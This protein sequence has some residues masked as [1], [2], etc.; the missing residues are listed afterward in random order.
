[1]LL[2]SADTITWEQECGPA[3]KAGQPFQLVN[4]KAG[5]LQVLVRLCEHYQ[6]TPRWKNGTIELYPVAR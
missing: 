5:H 2:I 6:F 4:A 3:A 1:V